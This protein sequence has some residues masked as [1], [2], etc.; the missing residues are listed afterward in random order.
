MT[1]H[2]HDWAGYIGVLLVLLAFYLLQAHRLHGNG[3]A[4]QLM[5][6]LGALGV[7]LSLLFGSFN[8]PAFI[9]QLA[10]LLIGIFGIARGAQRRREARQARLP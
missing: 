9:M 1:F 5:N 6:V 8:W 3:L 10:W 2:W 4:Y 7:M